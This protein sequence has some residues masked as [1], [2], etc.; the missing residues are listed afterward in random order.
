MRSIQRSAKNVCFN[1]QRF[2]L[3]ISSSSQFSIYTKMKTLQSFIA[4]PLFIIYIYDRIVN[5]WMVYGLWDKNCCFLNT[6]LLQWNSIYA[7][8]DLFKRYA[9]WYVFWWLFYYVCIYC[10]YFLWK[11]D[12]DTNKKCVICVCNWIWI[13]NP[14]MFCIFEPIRLWWM[15]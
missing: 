11:C 14:Y 2:C 13:T 4:T 12:S 5:I 8:C 9:Y 6:F 7:S 3:F 10:I 15:A 1:L